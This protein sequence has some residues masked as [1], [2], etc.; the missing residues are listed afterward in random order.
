M[1]RLLKSVGFKIVSVN[2]HHGLTPQKPWK[3]C[4]LDLAAK[5]GYGDGLNIIA[6]RG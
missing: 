3:K 2:T 4:L 5:M 6:A 1:Q